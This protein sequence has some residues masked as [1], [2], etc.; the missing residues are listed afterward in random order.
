MKA[1]GIQTQNFSSFSARIEI[2]QPMAN[3]CKV[4][5]AAGTYLAMSSRQCIDADG[6]ELGVAYNLRT[7]RCVYPQRFHFGGAVL[8]LE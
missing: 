1:I 4:N 3:E 7:A 6:C 5:A 8:K 2:A